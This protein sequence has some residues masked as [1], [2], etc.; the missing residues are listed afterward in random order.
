MIAVTGLKKYEKG[1][2]S[3]QE[4]SPEPRMKFES[5]T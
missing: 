2:F 5:L 1:L 3:K 4:V